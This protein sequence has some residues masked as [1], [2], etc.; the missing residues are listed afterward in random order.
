MAVTVSLATCG[1]QEE[2]RKLARTLLDERLIACANIVP[3]VTS[4]YRWEGKVNEDSEWLLVMKS[5][6]T[7]S[8]RLATRI[9]E[10]HS[11]DVPE[12]VTFPVTSGNPAYLDWV[13]GETA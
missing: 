9:R 10:L 5:T 1:S 4:I 7:L 8:E 11:Y 13:E 12:T 3:G 2:A 6:E